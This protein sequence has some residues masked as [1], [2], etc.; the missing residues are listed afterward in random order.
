MS[1][2]TVPCQAEGNGGWEQRGAIKSTWEFHRSFAVLQS[3]LLLHWCLAVEF[4]LIYRS[5]SSC[6]SCD[7]SILPNDLF[8]ICITHKCNTIPINHF[9]GWAC[10]INLRG[11]TTLGL[12]GMWNQEMNGSVRH[13]CYCGNVWRSASLVTN[14]FWEKYF[15]SVSKNM[16]KSHLWTPYP[17]NMLQ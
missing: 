9:R 16:R 4:I 15:A 8:Q 3:L 10:N 2:M 1:N 11:K 5:P 6:S 17:L 13:M 7:G 12:Y 14:G